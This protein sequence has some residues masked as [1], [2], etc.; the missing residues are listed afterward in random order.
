MPY[1]DP[2]LL[3][4]AKALS[5]TLEDITV[6]NGYHTDLSPQGAK[7]RVFRG[8][9]IFGAR[10]PLPMISIL[11]V[12]LPEDT[13]VAAEDNPVQVGPWELILQGFAPD[14]A[15]NPTDPAALMLA[16]VKRRLSMEKVRDHG[17]DIFGMGDT[18]TGL[19][20]GRGVVRPPDELSAKAYFW[21]NIVLDVVE[22][23]LDPYGE[24]EA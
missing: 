4:V 13:I 9:A 21:L 1:D 17:N 19:R 7:R 2:T 16:D 11:E 24:N 12:P 6:A 3:R 23:T 15:E 22:D 14:D 8:R 5:A 20:M 10:D 18:V